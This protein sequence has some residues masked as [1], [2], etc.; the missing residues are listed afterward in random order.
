MVLGIGSKAE[1]LGHDQ[2]HILVPHT[3]DS[4][5]VYT[6]LDCE[7]LAVPSI[8]LVPNRGDS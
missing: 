4:G 8:A 6:R 2:G 7:D 1:S 5:D 3:A